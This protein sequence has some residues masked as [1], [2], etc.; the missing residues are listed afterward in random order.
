MS[1]ST[2]NSPRFLRPRDLSE[3]PVEGLSTDTIHRLYVEPATAEIG[4]AQRVRLPVGRHRA[5]EVPDPSRLPGELNTGYLSRV[6][7]GPQADLPRP[8]PGLAARAVDMW[9]S[10]QRLRSSCS[11]RWSL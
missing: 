7:H 8:R 10:V 2:R 4:D 5:P 6:P 1:T 11:K 9:Q 3:S